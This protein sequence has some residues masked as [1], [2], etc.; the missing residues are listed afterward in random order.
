MNEKDRR[1]VAVPGKGDPS[2]TP[3]EAAFLST[4]EVDELI[5]SLSRKG[6]VSRG[7]AKE[8]SAGQQD[9]F[10]RSFRLFDVLLHQS[11]LGQSEKRATISCRQL[12][13]AATTTVV[14]EKRR[15]YLRVTAPRALRTG[16]AQSISGNGS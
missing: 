1:P 4:N 10:P 14:L 5:D 9:F 3:F 13:S 2:V 11:S 16:A 8:S 12:K 15:G 6:V 7:S